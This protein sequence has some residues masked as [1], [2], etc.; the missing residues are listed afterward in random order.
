MRLHKQKV[1]CDGCGYSCFKKNCG[2]QMKLRPQNNGSTEELAH[3]NAAALVAYGKTALKD[4]HYIGIL[5]VL[6]ETLDS[7]AKGTNAWISIGKN[8]AGDSFL[9]TY[10]EGN[11]VV[12]AGG[13][14]LLG[15]SD[16]CLNLLD[17]P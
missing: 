5:R 9:L 12:Y 4:T 17:E 6:A 2:V 16:E 7:A 13:H 11:E 3:T 10:H 14:S 1:P 8:R 15:L